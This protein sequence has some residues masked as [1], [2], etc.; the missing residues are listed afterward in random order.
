VEGEEYRLFGYGEERWELSFKNFLNIFYH[1]Y[2]PEGHST[3]G[4]SY[5]VKKEGLNAR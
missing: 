1:D 4:D 2:I 5:D 3:D